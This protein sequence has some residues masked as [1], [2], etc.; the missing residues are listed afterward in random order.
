[1]SKEQELLLAGPG[2]GKT[3]Y[4]KNL[5]KDYDS[6]E[7]I[8]ILSFTRAT[9]RDLLKNFK[10]KGID[11]TPKQCM[12]IHQLAFKVNPQK[13]LY[14]LDEQEESVLNS[15]SEKIDIEFDYLCKILKC[16]TFNQMIK[17]STNIIKNNPVYIQDELGILDF[18]I[19]DEYQDLNAM[20]RE[21]VSLLFPLCKKILLL[22]D[23]DQSIYEFKDASN[24]GIISIY[25]DANFTKIAYENMCYR[26]PGNIVDFC[27]ALIS[28]NK[29][30]IDKKCMQKHQKEGPFIQK[31]FQTQQETANWIINEINKIREVKE[32][33]NDSIMILSPVK[34]T[35]STLEEEF[36]KQNIEYSNLYSRKISFTLE[37]QI[38]EI[39]SIY[40][41]NDL[42][43]CICSILK[44]H[45]STK[46]KSFI[47]AFHQ[48][49]KTSI[50]YEDIQQMT[51]PFLK[52]RVI[53]AMEEDIN[54]DLYI[55][56][57]KLSELEEILE[58][59][60]SEEEIFKYLMERKSQEPLFDEQGINIMSIHK[61]KGLSASHVFILGLVD[62]FLPN[63]SKSLQ[64]IEEQRRILY[65]GMSRTEKSLYLI[66]TLEW[67]YN[68]IKKGDESA[69]KWKGK[70][71]FYGLTSSFLSELD[72]PVNHES[73]NEK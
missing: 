68:Q 22:G 9:I 39:S 8:L 45:N 19:I 44:G 46:T 66:S 42:I 10:E 6:T 64:S 58:E 3:T 37:Q 27:N 31:Q 41:K 70:N 33:Q 36:N 55:S 28:H 13:D 15:L 51:Y 20:E 63:K 30:R 17:N 73:K 53:K 40:L 67:T 34:I 32:Y 48:L 52:T 59:K 5:L 25:K 14:I 65:V 18:L 47:Q 35:S 11:I 21:F 12:T 16:E 26:C 56:N 29:D 71:R 54:V 57:N 49:L 62:G 69:F 24:E 60:D 4:I 38:W 61:S 23:D 72:K 1:M 50:E 7:N 2:T 43:P